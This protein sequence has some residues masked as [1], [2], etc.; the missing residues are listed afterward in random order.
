[1]SEGGG[2]GRGATAEAGLSYNSDR[3]ALRE[4]NQ[5]ITD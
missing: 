3:S 4:L 1:M 5:A 2:I